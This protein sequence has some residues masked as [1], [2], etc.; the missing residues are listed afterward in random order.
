MAKIDGRRLGFTSK[1]KAEGRDDGDT[2]TATSSI[3]PCMPSE[4]QCHNIITIETG[5]GTILTLRFV[6]GTKEG[7]EILLIVVGAGAAEEIG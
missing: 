5:T 6:R 4:Q 2:L 3:H 7:R 1:R